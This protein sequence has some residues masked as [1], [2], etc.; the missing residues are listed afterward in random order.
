MKNIIQSG[1]NENSYCFL[2]VHLQEGETIIIGSP[3][4][5]RGI[6]IT[7]ACFPHIVTQTQQPGELTRPALAG[8]V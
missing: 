5:R 1:H 7:C 3:C 8:P 4:I 2:G 6:V